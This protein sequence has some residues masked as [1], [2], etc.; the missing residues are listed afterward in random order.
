M[1]RYWMVTPIGFLLAVSLLSCTGS[2]ES[3]STALPDNRPP[4]VLIVQFSP[5]S[6]DTFPAIG[7]DSIVVLDWLRTFADSTGT[8]FE[9]QHHPFGELVA[10]IGPRVNG[11]DGFWLYAINGE[12][13]SKGV[14]D[15]RV[16]Y[17]DTVTFTFK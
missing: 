11:D 16:S 15:L 14:S 10:Q 8:A 5:D 7:T 17:R 1:K 12:M 2:G 3:E 6:A 9:T 4:G 13:A